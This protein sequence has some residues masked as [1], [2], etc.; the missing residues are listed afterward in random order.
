MLVSLPQIGDRRGLRSCLKRITAL[1]AADRGGCKYSARG[2]D[3][4]TGLQRNASGK[5][6][7]PIVV[8]SYRENFKLSEANTYGTDG[9]VQGTRLLDD[10]DIGVPVGGPYTTTC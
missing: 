8:D 9:M 6:D 3:A 2:L 10:K 4:V 1:R 5:A 7:L